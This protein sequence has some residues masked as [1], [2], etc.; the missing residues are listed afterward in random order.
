MQGSQRAAML[1]ASAIN[2]L[3]LASST[4]SAV[5]ARPSSPKLFMTSGVLA[6]KGARPAEMDWVRLRYLWLGSDMAL[7]CGVIGGS[8]LG[9]PLLPPR[10]GGV[11]AQAP[12]SLTARSSRDTA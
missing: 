6:R 10:V 12:T 11:P 8:A 2:S 7:A 1:S 9:R 3:V 5:A 4:P